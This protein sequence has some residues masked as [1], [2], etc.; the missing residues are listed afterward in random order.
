MICRLLCIVRPYPEVD[1]L[2]NYT[3][4]AISRSLLLSVWHRLRSVGIVLFIITTIL[5]LVFGLVIFEN[6]NQKL[7]DIAGL[8]ELGK[9]PDGHFMGY[10]PGWLRSFAT[11]LTPA[12]RAYFIRSQIQ[13]D[14]IFP[15]IYGMWFAASLAMAFS[16]MGK[17]YERFRYLLLLP[18][19]AVAFDYA[20]NL[21]IIQL[22]TDFPNHFTDDMA[23]VASIFT[24]LKWLCILLCLGFIF[25]GIFTSIRYVK[26]TSH[27]LYRPQ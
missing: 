4:S 11:K 19:L 15:I 18:F 14:F 21:T 24:Q 23:D 5:S 2:N 22:F 8:N 27:P 9:L 12:G 3:A 16:C 25:I 6:R 20:E 13:L 1:T 10:D 26:K 17:L 7:A